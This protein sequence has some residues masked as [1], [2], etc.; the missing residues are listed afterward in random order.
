MAA[1]MGD[2]LEVGGEQLRLSVTRYLAERR[3]D[4]EIAALESS[5]R[6]PDQVADAGTEVEDLPLQ[7]AGGRRFLE[8]GHREVCGRPH[9]RTPTVED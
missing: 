1:G 2:G 5:H 3:I 8:V 4:L 6:D 7:C 9:P